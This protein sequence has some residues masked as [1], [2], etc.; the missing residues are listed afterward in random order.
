MLR[1]GVKLLI[2]KMVDYK[3]ALVAILEN[4]LENVNAGNTNITEEEASVIIDHLTMLNKGVATVSKAY[5]CEHVLHITSNKFD[6]LVRK[7]IIPHGRKRL[8]FKEID[9][10]VQ[11]L[12]AMKERMSN[13]IQYP[14]N[15]NNSLWSA[16]DSEIGSLNDEQRNILFSDTK[17]IQI[18][19][20]LKQLVQE[21]LINSVKNVIEQSPNGKELL[22]Q[23]LNY[24]KSS[25]NAI[26]AES[27]RKLELFEKFQ[28]A[29]K[30]NPNLTY[31]EFCESI[32]K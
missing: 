25:K 24:I 19:N 17:Y 28:I 12:Q 4:T 31:K 6:Y 27:N 8:G 23:Q 10:R 22:T 29:A 32:N 14:N 7:G 20:Q 18:D 9:E 15:Q 26:V 13:T 3:K 5:A 30:A 11:Y 2:K 1:K 16:I 21:A